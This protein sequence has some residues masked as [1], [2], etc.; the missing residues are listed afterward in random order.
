MIFIIFHSWMSMLYSAICWLHITL[1][2]EVVHRQQYVKT[3]GNFQG[4]QLPHTFTCKAFKS[5]WQL[6]I[7]SM[8]IISEIF[9]MINYSFCLFFLQCR[10]WENRNLYF[11]WQ[12]DRSNQRPGYNQYTRLS[13]KNPST[14][15]LS[16]ANRGERILIIFDK[17]IISYLILLSSNLLISLIIGSCW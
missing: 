6:N 10:G 5:C 15:K 9:G 17:F 8:V 14:K 12:Y 13:I 16:G 7:I 3:Y 1:H 11:D 4:A 2:P